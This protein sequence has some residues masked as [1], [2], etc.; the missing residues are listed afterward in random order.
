MVPDFSEDEHSAWRLLEEEAEAGEDDVVYDYEDDGDDDDEGEA[1]A[2]A[3]ALDDE[4]EGEEEEEAVDWVLTSEEEWDA[5]MAELMREDYDEWVWRK[6]AIWRAERRGREEM[7]RG[8]L[9]QAWATS[10]MEEEAEA[11]AAESQAQSSNDIPHGHEQEGKGKGKGE[12]KGDGKGKKGKKGK[13]KNV[14]DGD[15]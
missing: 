15:L 10:M 1:E 12:G 8:M 13:D 4:D 9:D 2:E 3:E 7:R 5:Q 11:E 14:D 6:T